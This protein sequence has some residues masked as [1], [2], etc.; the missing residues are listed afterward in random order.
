MSTVVPLEELADEI[1]KRGAGYLLT[2]TADSRPHILH[3]NFAVD[4]TELRVEVGR[5][6]RINIGAQPAVSILWP[7]QATD[8][9]SLIVDGT[10]TISDEAT[11]VIIATGAVLHRPA[12]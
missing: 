7:A 11:A 8:E 3:L 1:A 10:A 9:Y 2:T 4:G 5:S 12:P 6:A